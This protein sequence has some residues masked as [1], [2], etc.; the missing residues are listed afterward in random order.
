ML[1]SNKIPFSTE[2]PETE[3]VYASFTMVSL[4]IRENNLS[5]IFAVGN[6]SCHTAVIFSLHWRPK[7]QVES[8]RVIFSERFSGEDVSHTSGLEHGRE[9][10][11]WEQRKATK[12]YGSCMGFI[13]HPPL[14]DTVLQG[15]GEL[16]HTSTIP[17]KPK[18]HKMQSLLYKDK[19]TLYKTSCWR[20]A[21]VT[22]F[23]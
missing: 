7:W 13:C 14:F 17:K 20:W 6:S 12:P 2:R 10:P 18:T 21:R 15:F 9:F 5:L 4:S 23:F 22:G 16:L 3:S 8:Q 19:V 11:S 1:T